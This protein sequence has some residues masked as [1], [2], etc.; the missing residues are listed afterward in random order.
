M[1]TTLALM[2]TCRKG[3]T[4]W[5][6]L[7]CT[8]NAQKIAHV[9]DATHTTCVFTA[10]GHRDE[11]GVH[12]LMLFLLYHDDIYTSALSVQFINL[13]IKHNN[14]IYFFEILLYKKII[15]K[16]HQIKKEGI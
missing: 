11:S 1:S 14:D 15:L 10:R 2:T 9:H 3:A 7:C 5:T 12:V 4:L 8:L 6:V 16:F 13:L